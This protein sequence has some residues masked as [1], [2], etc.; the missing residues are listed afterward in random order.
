MRMREGESELVQTSKIAWRGALKKSIRRRIH[1]LLIYTG[2]EVIA[3]SKVSCL[4]NADQI[5]GRNE[6]YVFKF[7]NNFL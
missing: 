1:A 2:G 4:Q 6:N 7:Q 5:R 3:F